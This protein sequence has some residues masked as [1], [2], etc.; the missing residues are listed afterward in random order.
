MRGG[1][2]A[3]IA[4]LEL[5]QDIQR[6]RERDAAR[7]RQRRGHDGGAT[8]S[9][10]HRGTFDDLVA[11]EVRGL[12][13]AAG[14]DDRT[15][16]RQPHAARVKPVAPL[17]GQQFQCRREFRL[18]QQIALQRRLA[19]VEKNTRIH[20]VQ[21]CAFTRFGDAREAR[22]DIEAIAREGNRRRQQPAQRQFAVALGK[23][24]HARRHP[25]NTDGGAA[26]QSRA[27]HELVVRVQIHVQLDRG[28]RSL[29]CVHHH[30][31]AVGGPVQQPET[32]AAESR[33]IGFD[34]RQHRGNGH[35]RV[36]RVAALLQDFVTRLGRQRVRGSD[37]RARRHVRA[38]GGQHKADERECGRQRRSITAKP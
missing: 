19:V 18:A 34:H 24:H 25:G 22:V 38:R 3:R 15:H 26:L 30:L 2:I 11:G 27:R 9:E 28:R 6:L 31:L 7:R 16:Q 32:A 33:R 14:S 23:M 17:L 36:E 29:A 1:R 12:P 20:P 4:Q 10:A 13:R 8:V 21:Q 5:L 37:R 35:R